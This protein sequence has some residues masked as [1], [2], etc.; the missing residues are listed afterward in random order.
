MVGS[1]PPHPQGPL[2]QQHSGRKGK[3]RLPSSLPSRA[4]HDVQLP[5]GHSERLSVYVRADRAS[6]QT[7][8]INVSF[9]GHF[10]FLPKSKGNVTLAPLIL[11]VHFFFLSIYY[12][13]RTYFK[14]NES[15]EGL[16]GRGYRGKKMSHALIMLK[17]GDEYM[18]VRYTNLF[19]HV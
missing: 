19:L 1:R 3:P 15:W 16:M 17:L 8:D 4:R 2:Q 7:P 5:T 6:A 13:A 11:S 14:I 12:H 10:P 9:P 18:G